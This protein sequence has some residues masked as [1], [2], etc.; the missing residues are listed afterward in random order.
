MANYRWRR[1]LGAYIVLVAGDACALMVSSTAN[2]DSKPIFID[3]DRQ[4]VHLQTF[5]ENGLIFDINYKE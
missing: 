1:S 2:Y 3:D 4:M 5:I